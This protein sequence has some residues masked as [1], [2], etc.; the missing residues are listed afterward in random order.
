MRVWVL[1]FQPKKHVIAGLFALLFMP[2]SSFAFDFSTLSKQETQNIA[3]KIFGNECNRSFDCLVAW[4][5]G[6]NF[7]SLGI[8]HF[9]WFPAHVNPPFQESFPNL[10]AW[11]EK[12]HIEKPSSL[13]WLTPQ[14][15]CPWPNKAAFLSVEQQPKIE[16]LRDWLARNKATQAAFILN[17][18]QGSLDKMLSV[19][20]ADEAKVIRDQFTRVA[21]VTGGGYILA[22]YVNFKGEGV[23]PKELYQGQGWGLRQVLLGMTNAPD[24][25]QSF[26]SAA[27]VVLMQRVALSPA[28]RGESRWL[29]GWFKRLDTYLQ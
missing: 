24:A 15:P 27:E 23:N 10:L 16:A 25:A 26:V 21:Q 1:F 28:A 19:S 22:D 14:T 6:E 17:R 5:D 2:T 8:G 4:N 9:I 18:L 13:S 12:H 29:K 20:T 3:E 11:M 7:A